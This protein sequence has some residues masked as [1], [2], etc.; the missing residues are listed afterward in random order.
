MDPSTLKILQGA[1]GAGG[2]KLTCIE[3]LF[4]VDVWEGNASARS[5][6]TGVDMTEGG[7]VWVKNRDQAYNHAIY[8]T[9]RGSGTAK[10]IA[11]NI[12]HAQGGGDNAND[13]AG[14]ISAFNNNGFSIDK[15]GSGAIDWANFNKSGDTYVSFTWKKH[16]KWFE[17]VTWNGNGTAGRVIPH[18]LEATP[19]CLMVKCT[20]HA[21]DWVVFHGQMGDNYAVLN[22]DAQ[23]VAS[24]T[25]WNGSWPTSTGFTVGSTSNVNES[26]K[27]YVAYLWPLGNDAVFGPN[28]DQQIFS[29]SDVSVNSSSGGTKDIGFEPSMVMLKKMSSTAGGSGDWYIYNNI[30]GVSTGGNDAPLRANL[31]NSEFSNNYIDFT[32]T[33]FKVHSN[34]PGIESSGA[35]G[36]L[37]W[38]WAAET[39]KTSKVP[40]NGTDVL[41]IDVA[42]SSS[43]A[44]DSGFPVDFALVKNPSTTDSWDVAA[45]LI[46]TRNLKITAAAETSYS[47]NMFDYSDSWL[48][49]TGYSGIQSWM[50]KRHA[51][52]DVVAYKGNST[53]GR[54]V[55]HN[56]SKIP[57]MIWIKCRGSAAENWVLGHI[58]L[59][60]G[61]NPWEYS[62]R[63]ND[64]SAEI[65]Y[66]YFNDTAPTSTLFTLNN[67]GQVN[68]SSTNSYLA[69]LFSSVDGISKVGSYTGNGSSSGPTI[70]LGFSPRLIMIKNVD[71]GGADWHLYD[72]V[73]GLGSSNEERLYL[74]SISDQDSG[75]DLTPSSTGFQVVNSWA[76][77]NGSANTMIYYAHA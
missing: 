48:D 17:I 4:S 25:H 2:E 35:Q 46:Q 19:R 9:E 55:Q 23:R 33:G 65:D 27:S 66:P 34:H 73:R 63:L 50:W 52:F 59:N 26:G 51:G 18:G 77:I 74:N 22:S 12:N 39:G 64:T 20:T 41:A 62:L 44:F 61:T 58:G 72:T 3:D 53:P 40:E 5:I 69:M 67:N 8:D 47:S 68:G 31:A 21:H 76:N 49:N 45:R 36:W 75:N 60:G 57:E 6:T 38:A 37:Y 13:W 71:N 29:T 56:L 16:P 54:T 28:E 43:P 32:S 42:G 70:S 1:A 7:M 24:N 11:S 10:R 14:Y 15:S 30:C